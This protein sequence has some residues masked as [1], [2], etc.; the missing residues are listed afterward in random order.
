LAGRE[1][2]GLPSIPVVVSGVDEVLSLEQALVENLHREDLQP[3]RGGG[4]LPA[5]DGGLPAHAGAGRPEGRQVRSS[6]PTT[7]RSVPAPAVDPAAGGGENQL[8]AGHAKALLGTP[9]RAFQELLAKR[10]V[11]DGLS[12]RRRAEAGSAGSTA[13]PSPM[14]AEAAAPAPTAADP[15]P[16]RLRAPG[17]LELEELLADT[18]LDEGRGVDG[19]RWWSSRSSSSLSGL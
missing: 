18:P 2:A 7:L 16:K 5:A 9:D 15:G 19:L 10:I 14:P 13:S 6:S 8:A 11:A 12:L 17:L 4:R 3:P 1:A